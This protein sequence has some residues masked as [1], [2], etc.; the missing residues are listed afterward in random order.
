MLTR[1]EIDGFKSFENFGMD[2]G[3]LTV[4]LGPNASGKSNLFDAIRLLSRLADTDLR[5]AVTDLRGEPHELFRRQP[6]G[7]VGK[8]MS[9]AVEVLLASEGRDQWGATVQLKH[10]RV[11]YEVRIERRRDARGI[12]RLVATREEAAPIFASE[13]RWRPG[14]KRPSQEFKRA[15]M[16]YSRRTPWLSTVESEGSTRFEIHQDLISTPCAR[17]CAPGDSSNSILRHCG[18]PARRLARRSWRRTARTWPECWPESRPRLE[19]T[20]GYQAHLPTSR[21]TSRTS[22]LAWWAWTWW[23]TSEVRSI[24]LIFRCATGNRLARGLYRTAPCAY[25]HC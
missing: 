14:G 3:P 4:I 11:R 7:T 17:S 22:S 10:T 23:K 6:D 15:F 13:D 21:R 8:A 9:F 12:E 20:Q 25:W 5:T 18:N 1:I 19:P 16:R 24:A 2:V